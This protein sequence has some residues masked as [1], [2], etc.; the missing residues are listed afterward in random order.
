MIPVKY[1]KW[2]ALIFAAVSS[3]LFISKELIVMAKA[4]LD[5]KMLKLISLVMILLHVVFILSLHNSMV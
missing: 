4:N 1:V 3:L 2:A 5:G